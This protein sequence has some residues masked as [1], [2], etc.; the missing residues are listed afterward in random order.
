VKAATLLAAA[1]QLEPL[2]VANGNGSNG[3]GNGNGRH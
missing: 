3:H 2:A 1:G